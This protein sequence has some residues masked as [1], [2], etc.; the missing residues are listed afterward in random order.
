VTD[1]DFLK[2]AIRESLKA[3][4]GNKFGAVIAKDGKIISCEHNLTEEENDPTS[5]AEI[6]AIRKACKELGTKNLDNCT[7]YSSAEPCFMCLTAAAWAHISKIVYNKPRA[8]FSH[9]DYH[10]MNFTIHDLN[11]YFDKTLE[12]V[13]IKE[14]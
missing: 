11:S 10:T 13:E 3:T 9:V 4:D 2:L 6:V 12:I 1:V 8:E 14:L 5:H 7:L